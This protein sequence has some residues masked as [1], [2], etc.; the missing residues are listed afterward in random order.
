[1]RK[2]QP[3][4]TG[5]NGRDRKGRFASGNKY[6]KGNP[7]AKRVAQLR[8]AL[9]AAIT[10]ADVKAIV[11]KLIEQAKSGDM[12]AIK[13]VLDRAVGKPVEADLFEKL[14]SLERIIDELRNESQEA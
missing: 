7:Y 8:S 1:M 11:K 5:S 12:V 6:A 3:T 10:P 4:E 14:E 9:L 13:E 2:K